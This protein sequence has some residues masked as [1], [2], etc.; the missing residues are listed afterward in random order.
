MKVL[1]TGATG[2]LGKHVAGALALHG[3]EVVPYSRAQGGDGR[4]RQSFDRRQNVFHLLLVA[5]A[6]VTA[7][8]RTEL[9]DVG[10]RDERA[11]AGSGEHD[12][13]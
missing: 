4:H 13:P 3:H 1:V 8:E 5:Q 6:V 7:I 11:L 10:T 2:F 12:G 9:G